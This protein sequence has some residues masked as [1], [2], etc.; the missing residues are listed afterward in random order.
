ML[1]FWPSDI[2]LCAVQASL[3]AIPGPRAPGWLGRLAGTSWA[4]VLPGSL[5][6]TIGL[7]AAVPG[8]APVFTWLALLA[9]PPLAALTLAARRGPPGRVAVAGI[10]ALFA[11][12]WARKQGLAGEAAALAIS[13]LGAVALAA[14]LARLA[15]ARA[16][17]VGILAMAVLD[18]VLVFSHGLQ[19]P[20][21]LLDRAAP[22][23]GLPRL[24]FARL[25]SASMGFGD[26]FV[27]AVLG[28]VLAQEPGIRRRAAAIA[29]LAASAF[30]ALFLVT[31]ELPATVPVAAALLVS[32]WLSRPARSR[33]RAARPGMSSAIGRRSSP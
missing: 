8:A 18:A 5:G 6:L 14:F 2:A 29:F 16:L 20:D 4:W 21:L 17:K 28:A 24:Q 7:I 12:A 3:V 11:L 32:E 25:G 9:L 33:R 27:A 26:L 30:D 15:P 19:H 10:A 23:A 1:G 22:P 13:G 31:N